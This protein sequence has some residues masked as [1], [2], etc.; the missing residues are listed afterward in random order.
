MNLNLNKIHIDKNWG[1]FVGRFND[2]GLHRH[3]ALQISLASQGTFEIT[4][5]NNNQ[6]AYASCFINSH[7]PHQLS[8]DET[9]LIILINPISSIGHQFYN[10]FGNTQIKCLNEDLQQLSDIFK[11]YLQND[12]AFVDLVN[13]T[14]KYLLDFKSESEQENHASDLRIYKAIQY[15]EQNFDRVVSLE[16]IASYCFLSET[17]FLHLFKEKTHLNFRRY[18]LW[19]KLIKSLPF[20][21]NQSITQT[22]HQFGFT[23][24]S[25]YTR[26]FKETFG[27]T[28]KF[29]SLKK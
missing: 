24:S 22:A 26:T 1:L 19:N 13:N 2:N 3:Y 16:E 7:V 14:S 25:H 10:K 12:L 18:Q 29:L 6:T 15:L 21:E 28:P 20:L 17:R 5:Q 27:L 8:S 23:D 11:G 4:D 9:S